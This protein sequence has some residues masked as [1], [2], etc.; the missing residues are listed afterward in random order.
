MHKHTHNVNLNFELFLFETLKISFLREK[1]S[2]HWMHWET[3]KI[4]NTILRGNTTWSVV[5]P[6]NTLSRREKQ[7][8]ELWVICLDSNNYHAQKCSLKK[9]VE[10][11]ALWCL[12]QV[13]IFH[14][15]RRAVAK[16]I[17]VNV[18]M[19]QSFNFFDEDEKTA[20]TSAW[21]GTIKICSQS[22]ELSSL[23]FRSHG[24]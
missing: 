8:E 23:Q 14:G 17:K 22:A 18:L 11:Q 7:P 19:L 12:L 3:N 24:I 2:K 16:Q 6:V 21:W 10:I 4:Y 20:G 15:A 5:A 1:K 13:H 9:V